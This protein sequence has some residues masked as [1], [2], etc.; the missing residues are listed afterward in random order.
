MEQKSG[1]N[2][3][4]PN[5]Q[6]QYTACLLTKLINEKNVSKMSL[7]SSNIRFFVY[8]VITSAILANNGLVNKYYM[9]N[10]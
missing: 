7:Y 5:H 9:R 6:H 1:K 2:K 10:L 4:S 8:F 3:N